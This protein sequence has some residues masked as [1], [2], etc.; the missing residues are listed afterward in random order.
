VVVDRR[1]PGTDPGRGHDGLQARDAR[2]SGQDHADANGPAA[3]GLPQRGEGQEDIGKRVAISDVL[4][5]E[6]ATSGLDVNKK[7]YARGLRERGRFAKDEA[8]DVKHTTTRPYFTTKSKYQAVQRAV[9]LHQ[10]RADRARGGDLVG[11]GG[12]LRRRPGL[13]HLRQGRNRGLRPHDPLL[14]HRAGHPQPS[15]PR[16]LYTRVHHPGHELGHAM[17]HLAGATARP[18][19]FPRPS[20]TSTSSSGPSS[21]SLRKRT[22][23]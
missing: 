2:Q 17:H 16:V 8:Q 9:R 22:L 15:G 7:S 23:T 14:G 18:S 1:E 5:P 10:R 19:C 12:H 3:A 13:L 11:Q 21:R 4:P 6:L 20:A